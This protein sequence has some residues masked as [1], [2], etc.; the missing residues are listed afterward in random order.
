[1]FAIRTCTIT[2]RAGDRSL[3]GLVKSLDSP[4]GHMVVVVPF[5]RMSSCARSPSRTRPSPWFCRRSMNVSPVVAG[6]TRR[7]SRRQ[8]GLHLMR[9][10]AAHGNPRPAPERR[11]EPAKGPSAFACSGPD[12]PVIS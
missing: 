6:S 12:Y 9:G 3:F 2:A 1:M 8:R 11:V 4:H 5:D 7:C 10:F